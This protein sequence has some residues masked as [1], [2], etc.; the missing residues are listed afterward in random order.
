MKKIEKKEAESLIRGLKEPSVIRWEQRERNSSSSDFWIV[1]GHAVKRFF[2]FIERERECVSI[3][4]L[5]AI[6]FFKF[7]GSH[8]HTLK[9]YQKQ[10]ETVVDLTKI[11]PAMTISLARWYCCRFKSGFAVFFLSTYFSASHFLRVI[12]SLFEKRNEKKKNGLAF[13][14]TSVDVF[15][16]CW[17]TAEL[18]RHSA[19]RPMNCGVGGVVISRKCV[20]AWRS[21]HCVVKRVCSAQRNSEVPEG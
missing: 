17:L 2:F 15:F 20:K 8:W 5:L 6:I 9:N 21:E 18:S 4:Y 1:K 11:F 3:L 7:L 10:E 19:T 13:D 12:D 14:S 16:K